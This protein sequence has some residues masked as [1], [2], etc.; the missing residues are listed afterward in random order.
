MICFFSSKLTHS[1]SQIHLQQQSAVVISN[2]L[3]RS[4]PDEY[5]MMTTVQS[6]S[7]TFFSDQMLSFQEQ[8]LLRMTHHR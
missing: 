2:K 1:R 8:R 7:L 5:R 3:F 4:V 6:I